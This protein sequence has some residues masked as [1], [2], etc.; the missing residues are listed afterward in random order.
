MAEFNL[1]SILELTPCARNRNL[2]LNFQAII[3]I[4]FLTLNVPT[5]S[6]L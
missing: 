5:R 6:V 4:A 3:N 2:H 1:V